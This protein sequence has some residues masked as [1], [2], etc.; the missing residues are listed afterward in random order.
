MKYVIKNEVTNEQAE[1][2][3]QFEV[4]DI[5]E[6]NGWNIEDCYTYQLKSCRGCSEHKEDVQLRYDFHG[7]ETGHYCFKC[8]NDDDKYRYRRDAYPTIE[9]HGFGERLN[10]DY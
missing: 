3:F 10:D 7:I 2:E 8:Y 1:C 9:T 4:N 5:L 6:S